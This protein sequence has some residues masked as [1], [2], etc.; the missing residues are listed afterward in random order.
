MRELNEV[1][2]YIQELE[3]YYMNEAAKARANHRKEMMIEKSK[4][5]EHIVSECFNE[6]TGKNIKD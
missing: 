2:K 3:S 1:K 4:L 6:L 5:C